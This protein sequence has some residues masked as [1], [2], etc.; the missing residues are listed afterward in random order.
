MIKHKLSIRVAADTVLYSDC[1][2]Y[3]KNK[4]DEVTLNPPAEALNQ[5]YESNG[6]VFECC[7]L[8]NDYKLPDF[9]EKQDN[10]YKYANYYSTITKKR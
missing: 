8:P 1:G 5:K 10:P 6:F 3:I 7:I 4:N 9:I 2:Y